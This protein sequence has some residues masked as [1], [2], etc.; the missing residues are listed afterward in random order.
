MGSGHIPVEKRPTLGTG[1]R[2]HPER[3]LLPMAA[4]RA[5]LAGV[6]GVYL[7]DSP[8]S[9]FRFVGEDCEK[10]GPARVV[11]AFGNV[12]AGESKD[13]QVFVN[14]GSIAVYEVVSRFM[15]KRLCTGGIPFPKHPFQHLLHLG[16]TLQP[17][18][19]PPPF[20]PLRLQVQKLVHR[21]SLGK[22]VVPHLRPTP[23]FPNKPLHQVSAAKIGPEHLGVIVKAKQGPRVLPPGRHQGRIP[24]PPGLLEPLQGLKVRF[25]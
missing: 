12:G 1:V 22:L 4:H 8:T 25:A 7:D 18:L 5:V 21:L 17:P 2:P 10:L 20:L 14:N 16:N 11:Y 24:R 19:R 9:L 13:V 23:H 6:L 3:L 15:C